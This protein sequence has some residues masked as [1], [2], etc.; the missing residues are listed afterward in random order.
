MA[1]D[2]KGYKEYPKILA[3]T[4]ESKDDNGSFTEL[5]YNEE[6]EDFGLNWGSTPYRTRQAIT[7]GELDLHRW[8]I[9]IEFADGNTVVYG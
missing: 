5:T 3:I 1:F 2:V 7:L 6:Y 4:I 8:Q 9:A